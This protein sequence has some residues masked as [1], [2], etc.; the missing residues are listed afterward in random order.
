VELHGGHVSAL[1]REGGG[2]SVV[3]RLPDAPAGASA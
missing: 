2:A 3:V 1:N